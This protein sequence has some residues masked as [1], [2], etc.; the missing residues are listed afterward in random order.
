MRAR[1]Q[2][3]GRVFYYYD[4]GGKPRRELPL[5]NDY[6]LALK[7]YTETGNRP[8]TETLAANDISLCR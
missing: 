6:T 2:K 3:S 5:G 1:V 4:L 8:A 7:K